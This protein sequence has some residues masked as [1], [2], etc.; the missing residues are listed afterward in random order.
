MHS[1]VHALCGIWI[2]SG[3]DLKLTLYWPCPKWTVLS[4]S[5]P[6]WHS[7]D[8]SLVCSGEW[9]SSQSHFLQYPYVLTWSSYCLY[10]LY[11]LYSWNIRII[12]SMKR[13]NVTLSLC[14]RAFTSWRRAGLVEV[15]LCI[16]SAL[17]LV[18]ISLR[19]LYLQQRAPVTHWI[20]GR[21]CHKVNLNAVA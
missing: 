7:T 4:A 2:R 17:V 15:K 21:V 19:Q 11:S 8:F 16:S 1:G 10:I 3:S 5:C 6:D 18:R 14:P 9:L 13:Y 12:H 20:R